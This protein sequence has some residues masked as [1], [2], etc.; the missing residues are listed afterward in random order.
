NNYYASVDGVLFN[1]ARTTLI[2]CPASKTGAYSI[3]SSVTSIDSNAFYYCSGLT[4]VTIGS[5]VTS[6]GDLAFSYCR[7]LTAINVEENN[8]YYA[9][10]DGVLFNKARTTLIQCPASKTG[11]YSIPSSVTSIGSS[12]FYYCSGLTSVTIPSSVTSI[13]SD[14]FYDCRGLTG[15]LTIPSSVTSIGSDAFSHCSGLTEIINRAITP[16]TIDSYVFYN[17]TTSSVKL[18]VPLQSLDAYKTA[19]VWKDF[20]IKT[21]PFMLDDANVTL[22]I[23]ET[24]TLESTF[25]EEY[26]GGM[27]VTWTSENSA[28]ATVSNDGTIAAILPGTTIIAAV[29]Q[30]DSFTRKCVVNVLKAD[31][32]MS[33]I[34]FAD[35]TVT[36]DGQS[37]SILIDET[38]PQGVS[39]NYTDNNKVNVG[40]YTITAAFTSNNYNVPAAKTA[41]LTIKKADID[42]SGITFDDKTVAYDGQTHGIFIG[43]TVPNRITDIN[44]TNNGQ[45]QAGVYTVTVSFTVDAAKYNTPA[46][47]TATL[48]ISDGVPVSDVKPDKRSGGIRLLSNIVSD[49]AVITV[50]LPNNERVSQIK[51]V[52]YDNIGNVVFEKTERGSSITWNLT[53]NAGRNVA[54]GT[55]LIVAEAIGNNAKTYKY[56]AKLGVRR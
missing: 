44:Y 4:S 8:N 49:K 14:A 47:L 50:D 53:N 31:I 18:F 38:L 36:Y 19:N 32:D 22:L 2:L 48:T 6:I 39:V 17:E 43:G 35:K 52:I 42:M 20:N 56:S 41:T 55:Y 40:V 24:Q 28:V 45:I 46:P 23:S 15:A 1:K 54:N 7:G 30:D 13:G 27:T 3:P 9:S 16:Q 26:A 51:A 5:G 34:T 25:I 11:A 12:A 37:H 21:M 10:V 33:A 29:V